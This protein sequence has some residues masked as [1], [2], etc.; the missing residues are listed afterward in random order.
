MVVAIVA[1]E[2]GFWVLL[3]A[4]LLTRY[5]WR[6][7]RLGAALLLM[8]PLTD[9]ALLALAVV[10]LRGGAPAGTAHGLAAVYLGVSVAF[11]H[12]MLRW[13]DAQVARRFHHTPPATAGH[14]TGEQAAHEQAA[15]EQAAG[16]RPVA[17]TGRPPRL[18][19]RAHAAQERRTWLRHLLAYAVSAVVLAIFTLLAGGPGVAAPL[20]RVMAPWAVVLGIDFVI[21]FSY[22]LAPRRPAAP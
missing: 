9:V 3:L 22:T 7:P 4:G 16:D 14:G 11:G 10:D 19:G 6:R 8:V 2:I 12:S 15:H 21:S 17:A 1:C 5:A 13:A 20:W 18:T